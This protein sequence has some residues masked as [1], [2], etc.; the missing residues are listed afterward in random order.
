MVRVA[1]APK[2]H[3]QVCA[4]KRAGAVPP[5]RARAGS[6]RHDR[7]RPTVHAWQ[8]PR[9]ETLTVVVVVAAAAKGAGRGRTAR[10]RPRAQWSHCNTSSSRSR[11]STPC[12]STCP[13]RSPAAT[14][15]RSRSRQRGANSH[16]VVPPAALWSPDPRRRAHTTWPGG[17]G[18]WPGSTLGGTHVSVRGVHVDAALLTPAEITRR[19]EQQQDHQRQQQ[20]PT[21]AA[22]AP[23]AALFNVNVRPVGRHD[24][25]DDGDDGDGDD[26]YGNP[27][28]DDD[29]DG[30]G[31]DAWT[32]GT[33]RPF[34]AGAASS[35]GRFASSPA[36]ADVRLRWP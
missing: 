23:S 30:S 11:R 3:A 32:Q 31:G 9:R 33:H 1:G 19:C 20:P 26:A 35:R 25:D 7:T 8:R 34:A 29:G 36:P 6:A 21:G 27:Y 14:S 16:K 10:S 28:G 18:R 17:H 4:E 13:S 22:G 12:S 5:P 24:D 2:A 15:T